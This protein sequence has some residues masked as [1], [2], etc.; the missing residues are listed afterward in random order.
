MGAEGTGVARDTVGKDDWETEVPRELNRS[1]PAEPEL[2]GGISGRAERFSRSS[3]GEVEVPRLW[4]PDWGVGGN[5][6][7]MKLFWKS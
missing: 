5:T 2:A 6:E 3:M 7:D 1:D 4:S